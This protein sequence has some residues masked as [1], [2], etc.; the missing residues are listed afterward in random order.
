M[1]DIRAKGVIIKQNDY[2][3]GHRIIHIFAEGMGIVKAVGYGAKKAKSRQA[4][5]SQ[6]LCWGNF[7]LYESGRDMLTLKNVDVIDGFFPLSEDITKLSLCTYISDITYAMLGLDNPDDRLLKVFLN[8]L[9]AL[10]YR[11]EPVLKI[12]S[13]YELKLMSIEG[14]EPET[15]RCGMCGAN[16]VAAFDLSKG[17]TVCGSCTGKNSVGMSEGVYRALRYIVHSPDKKMLSFSGNDIL[18]EKLNEL[19]EGYVLTQSDRKFPSLAYF[20]TMLGI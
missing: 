18:F 14:Y 4:A 13:V 7:E 20:K 17:M 1:A 6:F 8:T 16:R 11:N 5:S 10:A 2:G 12:K 19:S 3:E 9:Y 15:E